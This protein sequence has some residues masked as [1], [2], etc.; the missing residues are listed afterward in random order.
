MPRQDSIYP[1]ITAEGLD[2]A[3]ELHMIHRALFEA[4]YTDA[5][6]EAAAR[7]E[8]PEPTRRLKWFGLC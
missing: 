8:T 5:E 4:E 6:L 2:L 7:R 1:D 3:Y